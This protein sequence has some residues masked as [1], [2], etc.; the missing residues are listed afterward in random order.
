MTGALLVEAAG[1]LGAAA[2]LLA[3]GLLSSGRITA[4]V[5]Y[6]VLNLAGSV[7]LAV[8][9][10]AHSALPSAAVN[11]IWLVIG[12]VAVRGLAQRAR[13][14]RSESRPVTPA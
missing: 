4:G 3:Y 1:W 2:L 11:I 14:H 8:N 10:V 12:A 6:Q 13:R 5:G 7:A 9:A